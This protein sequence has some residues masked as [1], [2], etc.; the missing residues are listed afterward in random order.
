M[1][2]TL[3][4]LTYRAYA[5]VL[6]TNPLP[7]PRSFLLKQR[8]FCPPPKS[9][10]VSLQFSITDILSPS[11][12]CLNLLMLSCSPS[13]EAIAEYIMGQAP[14]EGQVTLSG[15]RIYTGLIYI[16]IHI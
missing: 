16:V 7:Y 6:A 15:E 13:V 8:F 14:R 11:S 5:T 9:T 3:Q 4:S 12:C 10:I 1:V 2:T